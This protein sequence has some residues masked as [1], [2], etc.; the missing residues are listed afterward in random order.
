MELDLILYCLASDV[1]LML[2]EPSN[3]FSMPSQ[4]YANV[5]YELESLLVSGLRT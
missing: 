4:T 1:M 5:Y 2:A 3:T